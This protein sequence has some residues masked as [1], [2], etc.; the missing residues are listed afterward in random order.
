[1]QGFY[2]SSLYGAA[3]DDWFEDYDQEQV[4]DRLAPYLEYIGEVEKYYKEHPLAVIECKI[5]DPTEKSGHAV[6]MDLAGTAANVGADRTGKHAARRWK[7]PPEPGDRQLD[8]QIMQQIMD[9]EKTQGVYEYGGERLRWIRIVDRD[10]ER[11]RIKLERRPDAKMVQI[12]R[13][14]Y[15][16]FRQKE[17]IRSLL[18]R[19]E[20]RHETLIK[21]FH[22]RDRIKLGAVRR[23]KIEKWFLLDE[24]REDTAQQKEFVEKALGTPDFAFLEGPPGSGKTTTLC[25]LVLQLVSRRKRVLFCASTHVAVDNL[26]EKLD[27]IAST[28]E[29]NLI[30]LRIGDSGK[31]SGAVGK[32]MYK[33]VVETWGKRLSGRLSRLPSPNDAQ[34][35]LMGVL[36]RDDTMGQIARDCANLVCGTAIGI[37]QHPDISGRAFSGT[38]D[39]MILDEA[40]KT[41]FQEFLVPAMHAGRWIIAGDARQLAPHTEPTEI[42]LHLDRCVDGRLGRACHD[43][44]TVSRRRGS[45][46]IVAADHA[47]KETY[48]A[49]CEKLGVEFVDAD[50]DKWWTGGA[51]AACIS[52]G[53]MI[54]AGSAPSLA[55]ISAG[56]LADIAGMPNVEIRSLGEMCGILEKQTQ[57]RDLNPFLKEGLAGRL[58]DSRDGQ[59]WGSAVGWRVG[60][61]PLGGRDLT[62]REEVIRR[63]MEDLMPAGDADYDNAKKQLETVRSIALP[64]ILQL[65]QHGHGTGGKETVMARG[66]P[67]KNFGSRHVLLEYQY[68]MHPEIAAFAGKHM[69]DGAALKTPVTMGPAREWRYG[70]YGSRLAWIDVPGGGHTYTNDKEAARIAG[71]I[72]TFCKWARKNSRH[73]GKPW[74]VAVLAFYTKQVDAIRRHL[75]KLTGSRGPHSFTMPPERG[76]EAPAATIE[77]RTLDAFQGHEADVVFLSVASSWP[78]AFLENPNRVNVAITRARY[79]QVVVGNREAMARSGSLLGTLARE[80]RVEEAKHG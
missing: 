3:V 69:Y 55:K 11:M 9:P 40:S 35:R 49:Q 47:L 2:A 77:L 24:D 12:L 39:V 36:R 57:N 25:E 27:G 38:F 41:T 54:V 76:R 63:D 56:K 13:N 21:L 1:M 33:N 28:T 43:V 14:T 16:L 59:A 66:I 6:W 20:S 70:R 73:D 52:R 22:D 17:A 80:A 29:S 44:F 67:R 34:K 48:R 72:R 45:A 4:R 79:Q 46:V 75:A 74:E 26:L 31:I 64:S 62:D 19:P 32:Y 78:T 65:L 51:T 7:K 37:L 30:P 53:S 58:P 8:P 10:A 5:I 50:G 71:E 23:K 60:T 68:R 15:S 42:A 61:L 18:Y